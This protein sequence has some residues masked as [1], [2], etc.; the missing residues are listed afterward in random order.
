MLRGALFYKLTGGIRIILFYATT[1]VLTLFCHI[2]SNP[3]DRETRHNVDLLQNVP[4]LIHRIPVRKLTL[5][6]VIHLQYLDGFTT[7]LAGICVRAIFK[8]QWNANDLDP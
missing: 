3:R 7:E 4:D 1:A 8:A 6:E 5:G 2:V